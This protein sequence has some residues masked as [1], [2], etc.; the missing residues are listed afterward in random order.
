M[1]IRFIWKLLCIAVVDECQRCG[2]NIY[3][4]VVS[5]RLLATATPTPLIS[6][7]LLLEKTLLRLSRRNTTSQTHHKLMVVAQ[8]GTASIALPES[9]EAG[10]AGPPTASLRAR[11]ALSIS[12]SNM[13]RTFA[14]N[15]GAWAATPRRILDPGLPT[16]CHCCGHAGQLVTRSRWERGAGTATGGATRLLRR[17]PCQ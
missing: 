3:S 16:G 4:L 8:I 2:S 6:P 7:L 9:P 1:K 15:A 13:A 5:L 10:A 11:I 12:S 17:S 14:V